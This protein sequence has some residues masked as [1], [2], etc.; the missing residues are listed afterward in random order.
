MCVWVVVVCTMWLLYVTYYAIFIY[1]VA[2][3]IAII[4]QNARY[5]ILNGHA[6]GKKYMRF[7]V[8]ATPQRIPKCLDFAQK[9]M[10]NRST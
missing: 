2:H 8:L 5:K 10:N 1:Y 4:L 6:F 3:K 7:Q 9:E